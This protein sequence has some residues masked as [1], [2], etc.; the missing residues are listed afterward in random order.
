[1][2]VVVRM[3]REREGKRRQDGNN[4]GDEYL[5]KGDGRGLLG[6]STGLLGMAPTV[7]VTEWKADILDTTLSR[8]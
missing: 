7:V 5:G 1:M 8:P 3:I 6:T 4:N 2:V